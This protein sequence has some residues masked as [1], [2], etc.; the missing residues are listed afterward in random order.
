MP[1]NKHTKKHTIDA[2]NLEL[3][4]LIADKVLA[5]RSLLER[6]ITTLETRYSHKLMRYGSY[7][8]WHSIVECYHD[9]VLFRAQLLAQDARIASLRRQ[10]IF[11]GVLS[12]QER[13]AICNKF[14]P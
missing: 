13:R 1:L 2:Q 5:D 4:S 8:L 9:P 3:H 14:A 11:T 6:A 12:E 10:T 7:L